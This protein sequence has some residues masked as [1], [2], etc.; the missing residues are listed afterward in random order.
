[1]VDD[2]EFVL[3]AAY[4]VLKSFGYKVLVANDGEQAIE[5][6]GARHREIDLVVLD[7]TM[8]GL[9]GEDTF[10]ALR[11]IDPRVMVLFS[12]AYDEAETVSQFIAQHCVE[13]LPK[14]YEPEQLA[15]QVKHL[16]GHPTPEQ[17]A[18]GP[19]SELLALH[20]AFRRQLPGRLAELVS[21]IHTAYAAPASHEALRTA[22]RLAHKL[23]GTAGSFGFANMASEM[24]HIEQTLKRLLTHA[25]P[26][27]PSDWATV[28]E[29]LKQAQDL[30]PDSD[31]PL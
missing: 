23:K 29:H 17:A 15:A 4:F 22:H 18:R 31:Q 10:H 8:P 27:V 25:T 21:A 12:T 26:A 7:M 14:P 28:N 1:V 2:D 16:L 3:Q 11:Q 9:G 6:F 20:A 24:A 19:E 30:L 13:F 5:V